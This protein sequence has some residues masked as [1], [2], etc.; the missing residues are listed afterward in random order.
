MSSFWCSSLK[1]F[2]SSSSLNLALMSLVYCLSFTFSFDMFLFWTMTSLFCQA[3]HISYSISFSCFEVCSRVFIIYFYLLS[4][5][6]NWCFLP[7]STIIFLLL[8]YLWCLAC[9]TSCGVFF[10]LG[11]SSISAMPL[12][13]DLSSNVE[14]PNAD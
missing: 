7:C 10:F 4:I 2:T 1:V 5:F 9:S 6:I 12:N 3:L 14:V 11:Y 8:F 13:L